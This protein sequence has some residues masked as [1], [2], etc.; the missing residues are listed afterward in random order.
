[1]NEKSIKQLISLPTSKNMMDIQFSSPNRMKIFLFHP[2]IVAIIVPTAR[3]VPEQFP[4]AIVDIDKRF[5]GNNM[6]VIVCPAPQC[7]LISSPSFEAAYNSSL[8][9][10]PMTQ[11][12]LSSACYWQ[13]PLLTS[14]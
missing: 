10:N 3:P 1:M 14:R 9:V 13:N 12:S 7:C 8:N 11:P 4:D 6:A 2:L 5:F